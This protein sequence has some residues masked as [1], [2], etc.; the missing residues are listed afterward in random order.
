MCVAA[1]ALCIRPKAVPNTHASRRGLGGS[2]STRADAIGARDWRV[3]LPLATF[4]GLSVASEVS[5]RSDGA[6]SC[7]VVWFGVF[8]WLAT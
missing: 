1:T 2:Q 5:K 7:S 4:L 8:V 6:P 3:L